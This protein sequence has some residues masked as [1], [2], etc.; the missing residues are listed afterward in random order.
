VIISRELT[1]D[2]RELLDRHSQ[3]SECHR[4]GDCCAHLLI[5]FLE[6]MLFD[7]E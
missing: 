2:L 5:E 3:D 6:E 7:L 4:K 1:A